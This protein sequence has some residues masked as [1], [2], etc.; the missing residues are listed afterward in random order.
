MANW[1][2]EHAWAV[3]AEG[4]VMGMADWAQA[5]AVGLRDG[6]RNGVRDV[7]IRVMVWMG[8]A[9]IPLYEASRSTTT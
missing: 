2:R 8:P 5:S 6:A 9:S 7:P 4:R 3:G 1:G